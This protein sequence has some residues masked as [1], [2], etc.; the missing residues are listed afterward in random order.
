MNPYDIMTIEKHNRLIF[1]L[2]H[3]IDSMKHQ[4]EICDEEIFSNVRISDYR[5]ISK[6]LM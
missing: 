6:I 2:F 4:D 5:R 1:P 3:N